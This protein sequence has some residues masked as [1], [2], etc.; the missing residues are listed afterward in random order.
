MEYLIKDEYKAKE[1]LIKPLELDGY[2]L[3]IKELQGII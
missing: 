3:K 2:Q 1:I